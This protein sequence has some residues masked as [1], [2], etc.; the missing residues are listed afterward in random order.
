MSAIKARDL[1]P[2]FGAEIEGFTFDGVVDE[3]THRQLREIFDDRGVLVFRGLD[4]DR[5]AQAYL[6]ELV[7]SDEALAMDDA[8]EL[9]GK[10]DGFWISNREPGAAAPFG[11]L[12]YHCD[13][14]WSDE[15][16]YVNSLYGVD[17]APG[18]VP[19]LFASAAKAW[20]T[21]PDSLRARVEGR[22]A[23]HVTG[24]EGFDDR[25]RGD[26][27]GQLLN[28][29][30]ET[31]LSATTPVGHR[32]PRTGRTLLYVSQGMTKEI[33]GL[34]KDESEDL[35]E[36]LF[37]HLYSPDN[38]LE[39]DWHN[40][41]LVIW[42]NLALQHARAAVNVDGPARTLRKIGSPIPT[43]NTEVQAYQAMG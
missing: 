24:P 9:A 26:I 25:R 13:M 16:F 29:I 2:G 10:Q 1:T 36:E 8:A 31:T 17:V 42:D 19:T 39:H 5:V 30:R 3:A 15:P 43:A 27:D 28:P 40:G 35:L 38:V 7:I 32:H 21:L 18:V 14:M 20:D 22:S 23:V 41:D 34:P 33:V 6:S 12:L 11:R 37:K 4:I